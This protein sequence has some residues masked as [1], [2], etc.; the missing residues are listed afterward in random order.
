MAGSNFLKPP[1]DYT[2]RRL[3]SEQATQAL[4]KWHTATYKD[5]TKEQQVAKA[6]T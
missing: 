4:I 3:L 2:L 1:W 5:P 6:N